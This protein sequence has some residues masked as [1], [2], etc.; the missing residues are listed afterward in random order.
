[1]RLAV[2]AVA[3]L[4]SVT[5]AFATQD[6]F[7]GRWVCELSLSEFTPDGFKSHGID[8]HFSMIADADGVLTAEGTETSPAG[9]DP[10]EITGRWRVEYRPQGPLFVADGTKETLRGGVPWGF[11][12]FEVAEGT[13]YSA[14]VTANE[15][16][17][18]LSSRTSFDCQRSR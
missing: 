15:Q 7:I 4:G 5:G 10:F 18:S 12:A 11:G 14:K 13:L 8:Q 9:K 2:V 16:T 1:M 3:F 6:R 17:G